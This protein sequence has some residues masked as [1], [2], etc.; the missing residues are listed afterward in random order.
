M[1]NLASA[2]EELMKLRWVLRHLSRTV[3]DNDGLGLLRTTVA[4][5][6]KWLSVLE[7]AEEWEMWCEELKHEWKFVS[8][9]VSGSFPTAKPYSFLNK[10]H[11]NCFI[12]FILFLFT[13]SLQPL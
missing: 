1:A 11:L 4:L 8:E 12:T 9:G 3:T 13:M 10:R 5:W 6:E 2:K 7:A